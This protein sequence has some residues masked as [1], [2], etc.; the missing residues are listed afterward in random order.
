MAPSKDATNATTHDDG[1][2]GVVPQTHFVAKS[3]TI[4]ANLAHGRISLTAILSKR[5]PTAS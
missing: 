2:L 4:A 1:A 5:A 3:R